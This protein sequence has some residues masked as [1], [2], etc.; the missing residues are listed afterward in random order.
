MASQ[1]VNYS[2]RLAKLKSR[3]KSSGYPA[4]LITDPINVSYLTGFTGDSTYLLVSSGSELLISDT[5]YT[6]Q[7]AEECAGI[8]T[9]IRD[10]SGTTLGMAGKAIQKSKLNQLAIEADALTKASFDQLDASSSGCELISTSGWCAQQRAIKDKSELAAIRRS[11]EVNQRA[12]E[13][14]RAQL[15]GEQTELDLAHNLEQQIR[16]FGG[17]RCAFDPIVGV[18]GRAALPHGTPT[19]ARICEAPFVLI[20]WG[21]SVDRYAS[22]ITRVLVTGKV[23]KRFRTVYE[24]VL[25][26]QKAAISK[27]K[28]GVSLQ[29]VDRAA[30]K[31]IDDAGFGKY[32]GHG[33]GHGFGLQIHETPYISPIHEGTFETGMVVTI[34]PGIY[35]PGSIGV[36]IEDDILVTKTGHEVLSS[37]PKELDECVVSLL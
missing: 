17:T 34:E 24:T 18:G 9:L 12:F 4:I 29:V 32:F 20:D 1:S 6:T 30:R 10:S 23:S 8:D 19:G 5:R 27:I 22:D 3:L 11:I 28:P 31:I 26:A 21:A 14:V 7:L 36:R 33:L 13:V 2:R 15:R 25:K 35:I 16:A 37:L